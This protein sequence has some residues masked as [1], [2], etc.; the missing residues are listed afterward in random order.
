VPPMRSRTTALLVAA[1]L[2]AGCGDDEQ[3]EPERRPVT[4]ASFLDCFQRDGYAAERPGPRQESVL[5]FQAKQKGFRVE[6]VNVTGEQKLVPA[7]FLV[8]FESGAKAADAVKALEATSLGGQGVVTRGPA[9]VGY[10]DQEERAAVE[11]AVNR[12]L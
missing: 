8:F 3:G 7:A 4:A 2:A 10:T 11:P 1:L 9:V 5:A 6:P 12:C